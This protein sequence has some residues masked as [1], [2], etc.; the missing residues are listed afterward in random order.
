MV[1]IPVDAS[2]D[3]KMNQLNEELNRNGEEI[4]AQN[5]IQVEGQ[6]VMVVSIREGKKKKKNLLLG[7][8]NRGQRILND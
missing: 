3:A 7:Q 2:F 8:V 1:Q 6:T 5:T 4:V